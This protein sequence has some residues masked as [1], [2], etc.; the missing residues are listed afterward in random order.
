MLLK[1]FPSPSIFPQFC[2]GHSICLSK[3]T[4]PHTHLTWALLRFSQL[5]SLIFLIAGVFL[6]FSL[7]G[8]ALQKYVTV[9]I[10]NIYN[11]IY[12]LHFISRML[13]QEVIWL[14]LFIF[15]LFLLMQHLS[16]S[17][18]TGR[19][20]EENEFSLIMVE[21]AHLTERLNYRLIWAMIVYL[22]D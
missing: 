3:C 20:T 18:I 2:W 10:Y 14:W 21:L 1:K 12:N 11:Y 5:L 9:Y 8:S 7:L 6:S 19:A 16:S 17:Q 13:I 22:H 4:K 15:R